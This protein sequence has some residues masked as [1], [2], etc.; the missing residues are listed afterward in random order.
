MSVLRQFSDAVPSSKDPTVQRATTNAVDW[1]LAHG[2]VMK[3]AAAAIASAP[4]TDVANHGGLAQHAP[5]ALFPTPFPKACFNQVVDL[6]PVLNQLFDRI[7]RDHDFLARCIESVVTVDEFTAQLYKVYQQTRAKPSSQSITLGLHRSDYLLH[8]PHD[9]NDLSIY[10]VEFNTISTSFAGLAPVTTQLHRYLRENPAYAKLKAPQIAVHQTEGS[11]PNNTATAYLVDGLAKAWQLY[12]CQSAVVVMAVQV[13]ERNV[14]DQLRLTHDL[15]QRYGITMVRQTLAELRQGAHLDPITQALVLN[16]TEVAVV[17]YRT[18]YAPADYASPADWE[19]R[20]MVEQSKAIKAPTVA[21][22]L[23]GTKKVQQVLTEPSVLERFIPNADDCDH[24]RACFT[25]LY[26]LDN[27][28]LGLDA[29]RRALEAPEGYVM[30]PQREGG[31]NNVYGKD[32]PVFL[33]GLPVEEREAYIL[34]DLI[35]PP[36]ISNLLVHQGLAQKGEV[37]SELGIYGVWLSDHDH[38]YLNE[39]AGHIL[40]TKVAS[41][42]EGGIAAG[43]GAIDSPALV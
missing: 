21:Y 22:Q 17:Y 24:V 12:G 34:M 5:F 11:L 36:V 10:Q 15:R 37:I 19:T 32:I 18:C 42:N 29:V 43:F 20:L 8:Q 4:S 2:L 39:S 38:V 9:S 31:G 26:P 3:P 30:K 16:G 6:Q 33:Q 28:P 13:G 25:G 35:K 1:A 27:S 40:R 7:A 23:A 41:S 14:F